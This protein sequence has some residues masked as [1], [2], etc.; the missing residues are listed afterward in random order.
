[1]TL[2]RPLAAPREN[3]GQRA[4]AAELFKRAADEAT[5]KPLVALMALYCE[6]SALTN[7]A[8]IEPDRVKEA[9]DRLLRFVQTY[10]SGRHIIAAHEDLARLQLNSGDYAGAGAT[11]AE[12]TKPPGASHR[13]VVLHARSCLERAT[14]MRPAP[15]STG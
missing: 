6:A 14:T 5:N 7:L 12:L 9:K 1:M 2:R 15:S 11:I 8:P 3:A 10:P 13:A 4:E